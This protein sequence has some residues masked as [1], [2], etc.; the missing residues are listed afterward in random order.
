MPI[1]TRGRGYV[2]KNMKTASYHIRLGY[3]L[4]DAERADVT[5]FEVHPLVQFFSS[6]TQDRLRTPTVQF[7]KDDITVS[8]PL[9]DEAIFVVVEFT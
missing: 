8:R 2:C 9:V 7:L 6:L 5:G 1:D 3:A 4:A